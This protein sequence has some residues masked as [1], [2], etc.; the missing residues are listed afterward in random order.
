MTHTKRFCGHPFDYGIFWAHTKC[1]LLCHVTN[2]LSG[3]PQLRVCF[4]WPV[5]S[6]SVQLSH[7]VYLRI[8]VSV[9][10]TIQN[11]QRRSTNCS[12][13]FWNNRRQSKCG[14]NEHIENRYPSLRFNWSGAVKQLA[15]FESSDVLIRCSLTEHA[16][17]VLAFQV[18]EKETLH[19]CKFHHKTPQNKDWVR[20]FGQRHLQTQQ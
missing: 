19:A 3:A 11:I 17:T 20:D 8:D 5:W 12:T 1:S 13:T 18:A 7:V 10:S 9:K 2:L 14:G 15:E 6:R 16:E 4:G